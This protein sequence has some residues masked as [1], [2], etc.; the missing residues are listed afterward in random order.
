MDNRLAGGFKPGAQHG[1]TADMVRWSELRP[2]FSMA[3]VKDYEEFY[4]AFDSWVLSFEGVA[5][6]YSRL[7]HDLLMASV[8]G[9]AN[10]EVLER[11]ARSV[12]MWKEQWPPRPVRLD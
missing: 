3:T 7:D 8:R 11:A 4:G 5:V 1:L 6:S 9:K 2:S 12:A 10:P